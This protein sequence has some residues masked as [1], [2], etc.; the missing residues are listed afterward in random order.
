MSHRDLPI[1]IIDDNRLI[2]RPDAPYEQFS[3]PTG[4]SL[5]QTFIVSVL[6]SGQSVQYD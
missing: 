1:L 2:R 6:L 4:P 3:S 5:K